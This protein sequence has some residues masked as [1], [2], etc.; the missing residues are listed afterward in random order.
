MY[1]IHNNG[2]KNVEN[3]TNRINCLKLKLH[4]STMTL[5]TARGEKAEGSFCGNDNGLVRRR[6]RH[7][8]KNVIRI[9]FN[10]VP[11]EELLATCCMERKY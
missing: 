2:F 7:F 4:F 3:V 8:K 9:K 6:L 11:S 10:K 1:Y 5:P